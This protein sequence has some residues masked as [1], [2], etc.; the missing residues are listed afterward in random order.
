MKVNTAYRIC[1]LLDSIV[2]RMT[3]EKD[4][5]KVEPCDVQHS[6]TKFC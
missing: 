6:A 1:K 3:A 5:A 4:G 2:N